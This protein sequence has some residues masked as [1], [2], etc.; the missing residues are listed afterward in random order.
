MQAKT[1]MRFRVQGV[2][3]ALSSAE[4]T[5]VLERE[6]F[7]AT[8]G[9]TLAKALEAAS[10]GGLFGV[11]ALMWLARRQAGETVKYEAVEDEL[12]RDAMAGDLSLEFVEQGG[13]DVPDPPAEGVN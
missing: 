8:D 13:G 10:A 5:G 7:R 4:M 11:A 3:Y 1:A 2:D 6:L 12:Y 9:F